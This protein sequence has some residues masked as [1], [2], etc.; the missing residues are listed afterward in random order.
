MR[1]SAQRGVALVVTLIMLSIITVMVV[2]FLAVARRERAAVSQ[3]NFALGAKYM[4]DAGFERAKGMLLSQII[5]T[6]NLLGPDLAVSRNYINPLGFAPGISSYDNV[7]YDF[8][9][10]DGQPLAQGEFL[11]NL[12]N[13]LYD[14]RP[15]VYVN[16]SRDPTKRTNDFRYYVDLNRNRR[17]EES[18]LVNWAG[19]AV[20]NLAIGQYEVGDPQWIGMLE[21]PIFPHSRTNKFVGRYAFLIHPVGMTLD[22][23]FM[24]NH[25]KPIPFAMN[26][27]GFYRNQGYGSWE[28]NLAAFLADLNTNVWN[29]P[30]ARRYA[31][32]PN[33]NQPSRGDAFFDAQ[34]LLT[35]RYNGYLV[36]SNVAT[37]LDLLPYNPPSLH[38]FLN[39]LIDNYANGPLLGAARRMTFADEANDDPKQPW[40]GASGTNQ[41][42]TI[43][44][45]WRSPRPGLV[46][47]TYTNFVTNLKRVSTG[48]TN[49]DRYTFYHLLAQLGSDSAAE[50]PQ[51]NPDHLIRKISAFFPQDYPNE[52]VGKFNLNYDNLP[53][54]ASNFGATNFVE[55]NAAKFFTN[56]A[57][58]LLHAH[59]PFGITN[60]PVWPRTNYLFMYT[61]AVHRILQL[62]ANIY[63]A[64]TNSPYPSVFRPLFSVP[65]ASNR[66]FITGY[67]QVT[68][69]TTA[70]INVY[71]TNET[72]GV[73]FI[74]GAKKGIPNFNEYVMQTSIEA[75]RKLEL[76][77]Q[78]T[79]TPIKITMT[80]EMFILSISNLFA[81]E[82]WN[83][84]T[85]ACA[86]DLSL[87]VRD[88]ATFYLTNE[89]RV[90]P[91]LT[92]SW[93]FLTPSNIPANQ[94][95]GFRP[96]PL[97]P[98]S[99]FKIPLHTN[100]IL[101][102]NGVYRTLPQP[103]FEE[104][105]T[106]SRLVGTRFEVSTNYV[107]PRWG[108][109]ISNRL[110]YILSTPT[111]RI[112]DY[113]HLRNLDSYIDISGLLM[114]DSPGDSQESQAVTS[115]WRTNRVGNNPNAPTEGIAN[116]ISVSLGNTVTG[117][118]DWRDY[119][120]QLV[121]KQ[122][123]IDGFR[124]FFGLGP[125]YTTNQVHNEL[126]T[127]QAP[128]A[129]MR[130]MVF[131]TSWQANDPLVHH[132]VEHLKDET[133]NT[134]VLFLKPLLPVTVMLNLTNLNE[135][136]KP[137]GG[138]PQKE[139]TADPDGDYLGVKDPGIWKSDDWDFPTNKFPSIGWL[140]RVHRGTPW[141]T[142]YLKAEVASPDR[143]RR[144]F[145]DLDF[146][147]PSHPTNDWRLLDMFTVAIHPN[148]SHGQLSINQTNLAAWSA[149]LSGV[150]VLS[151]PPPDIDAIFFT[152][153]TTNFV[154]L[155]PE[156]SSPQLYAIVT[157]INDIRWRQPGHTF[158]RLGD[159]LSVPE[160]TMTDMASF[161]RASPFLKHNDPWDMYMLSDAAIERIPQQ[162]L[163]L[164]KVGD[165]RYVIYAFGQSLKPAENSV[166]TSGPYFGVCTN[167][168]IT[169][170]TTVRAVLRVE[171]NARAP[172][173]VIESFNF[174]P[175]E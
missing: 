66:V 86:L 81:L 150:A 75:A 98:H 71:P 39:D 157:N 52:P 72:Y 152:R 174:L 23:N 156:P 148:A 55:W 139:L 116:Q 8:R 126:L 19:F 54:L 162:I 79:N 16:I 143:W 173:P 28:I 132:L 13:L 73:P 119:N 70:R 38:P 40:P 118:T 88:D 97:Q 45:F 154:D 114:R 87:R 22:F 18:G 35:W 106:N 125:I 100:V 140:G 11:Q 47:N 85:Q 130:R 115:C 169:G 84:Y 107:A 32:D 44:D 147:V 159:L 133:N 166:V 82:S 164:L 43:H 141:Q 155:M 76:R 36:A 5:A 61:P 175:S 60:I 149:I 65:D 4:A 151:N 144:Q 10:T 127:N 121:D 63:D 58:V 3:A 74:V 89:T 117:N 83:S 109:L 62:V 96:N 110:T 46:G 48:L 77:R 131:T 142:V 42:F 37:A 7:N 25:A 20:T 80:N 153:T 9:S 34:G 137:W 26:S 57:N 161:N 120:Y 124:A 171:G 103:H 68:N 33:P 93:T 170:E 49:Y 145:L 95:L 12:T 165:A 50:P 172:R 102:T 94:W 6:T 113:V 111:G 29:L 14:P 146:R 135:R 30:G 123:G 2:A 99:G 128:F 101:L 69:L 53:D 15:P 167:Y 104:L 24:Y 59:Y 56:V 67:E 91:I 160:L 136:Y 112:L 78:S 129:P 163:S 64:G 31:F 90:Y 105:G 21:Q 51:A 138:N 108:L 17:F 92:Q 134:S 158:R 41:F 122:A 27:A 1:R 168:Q